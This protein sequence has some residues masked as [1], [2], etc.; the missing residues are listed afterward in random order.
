MNPEPKRTSIATEKVLT[1]I[2]QRPFIQTLATIVF[3]VSPDCD[4]QNIRLL[5]KHSV[6]CAC[7]LDFYA[8]TGDLVYQTEFNRQ[9]TRFYQAIP[10]GFH[11]QL[12]IIEEDVKGFFDDEQTLMQRIKSGDKFSEDDIRN[13]LLGK[14]GDNIFYGKLLELL[15]PEWNLTDELR[16]QTMLFDIGKDLVDYEDDVK[17]G[18]PNILLMC[19][20]S[21]IDRSKILHLATE[22]KDKALSSSN[23]NAS[24]TL[25]SAIEQ[26]YIQITERL[27]S[28]IVGTV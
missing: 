12:E 9:R 14:S 3:E 4:T 18:L 10:E 24:P 1:E 22:L 16:I 17:N 5:I 27:S 28:G 25:K 11:S 15:V 19:L 13:Y 20:Q 2:D 8:E 7:L 21:G 26:N 6:R 23:I